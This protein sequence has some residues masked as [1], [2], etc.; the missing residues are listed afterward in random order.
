MWLND[1]QL[2][3][4]QQNNSIAPVLAFS[5]LVTFL[6][7][8]NVFGRFISTH[9]SRRHLHIAQGDFVQLRLAS[10]S[11]LHAI[12]SIASAIYLL[13]INN[14]NNDNTSSL[15]NTDKASSWMMDLS[16]GYFLSTLLIYT[17]TSSSTRPMLPLT[18]LHDTLF[19]LAYA[20]AKLYPCTLSLKLLPYYQLLTIV[21]IAEA[22]LVTSTV[23]STNDN[24]NI[25][26][27]PNRYTIIILLLLGGFTRAV[28]GVLLAIYSWWWIKLHSLYYLTDLPY[29]QG[30]LSP[31]YAA[32]YVCGTWMMATVYYKWFSTSV[33]L[34]NH[35]VKVK[36]E[37][38]GG[39]GIVEKKKTKKKRADIDD[40]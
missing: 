17:A 39:A 28:V 30:A 7:A 31:W 18:Y 10:C 29:R 2:L 1:S 13:I 37:K 9:S 6:A 25:S 33:D 34:T 27:L 26:L 23:L 20:L 5:S 15:F 36:R 12:L 19:I 21:N 32:Y 40:T 38:V 4:W 22:L 8:F 11:V 3:Q 16:V 35:L 24:N 14:N